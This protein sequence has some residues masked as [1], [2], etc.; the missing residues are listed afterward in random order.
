MCIFLLWNAQHFPVFGS[1]TQ[2]NWNLGLTLATNARCFLFVFRGV[3]HDRSRISKYPLFDG[4]SRTIWLIWPPFSH[5]IADIWS[6]NNPPFFNI[7]RT[8]SKSSLFLRKNED[9]FG[10]KYPFF[11]FQG[12]FGIRNNTHPCL[13]FFCGLSFQKT[14][15]E[16]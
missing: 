1:P 11:P 15:Q 14:P 5:K 9:T 8:L 7:S 6:K 13:S 12:Q 10:S 16:F 2:L 3:T 4:V